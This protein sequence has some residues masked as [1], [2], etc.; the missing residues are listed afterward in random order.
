MFSVVSLPL[1]LIISLLLKA[2]IEG[3]VLFFK[4]RHP[5]EPVSF[6]HRICEDALNGRMAKKTRFAKRFTPMTQMGKANE[7]SLEEVAKSVLG[8]VFHGQETQALKVF[9]LS[10]SLEASFYLP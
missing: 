4:T 9:Q 7:K 1:M 10:L 6:V 5:V 3:I 2:K 8:P